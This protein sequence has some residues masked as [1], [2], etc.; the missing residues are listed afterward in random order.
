[1]TNPDIS[2][3]NDM[4]KNLGI[5]T[6]KSEMFSQSQKKALD[7]FLDGKNIFIH[8]FAG[9]GKSFLI[10]YFKNYTQEKTNKIIF[11]TATT[12]IAAYNI[13]GITINKY[14]GVGTGDQNVTQLLKSINRNNSRDTIKLTDI[15]II[16]E[17]SMMSAELFEK[18][19]EIF[20]HIRQRPTELFGGIQLVISGD[21]L[22]LLPVFTKNEKLY[23]KQD[24]RL[25]LE[26]PLFIKHFKRY[27]KE[28]KYMKTN[29]INLKE[30]FR[31]DSDKTFRDLLY[32]LRF[33]LLTDSDKELLKSR[34]S[35]DIPKKTLHLVSSNRQANEINKRN[36]DILNEREYVFIP[37]FTKSISNDI[38]KTLQSDLEFQF[39][40][41]GLD[42]LVLKKGSRIMLV[43]NLDVPNGLVNGAT[44]VVLDV[45]TIAVRVLFDNDITETISSVTWTCT[46]NGFTVSAQQIPLII[47]F[48]LTIHKCQAL[49]LDS[50]IVDLGD[51]IFCEHQIYVAL[52]R[53]R[54]LDNVY[55]TNIS[56][57]KIKVNKKVIE[58]IQDW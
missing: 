26:S 34:V 52:S 7:L 28:T 16:D 13:N 30:N 56:F 39:R 51:S 40:Q 2:K 25:L 32:N 14:A 5:S 57:D 48:G 54:N 44:G 55:I 47:A 35:K 19:D 15:L 49:T 38:T 29:I 58:F 41:R 24:K 20:R 6:D 37:A 31:Q 33:G 10:K 4:L 9:S 21:F 27:K 43:K 36:I 1:M 17:I 50:V 22:Q 23:G 18:L 3:Y 46:F 12:G 53:A 42:N 11:V 45:N 8:G